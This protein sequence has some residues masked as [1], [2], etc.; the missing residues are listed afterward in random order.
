MGKLQVL[1]VESDHEQQRDVARIVAEA[2]HDALVC[3]DG[4]K[5]LAHFYRSRPDVL[6]V[7]LDSVR[8]AWQ[9]VE[10]IRD[11]SNVPIFVFAERS[12]N[13]SLHRCFEL[14]TD[15][16]LLRP[17]TKDDL[18]RSFEAVA[19]RASNGNQPPPCYERNGLRIDWHSCTVSLR[20]EPVELTGTEFRL[21]KYLVEHKGWVLSHDQI[22][23]EVWGPEYRG[24]KDRVKLYVWYLRRKI[25]SDPC[26]PDLIVTKRGLGYS[27]VG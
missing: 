12:T 21:L 15:G 5:G 24:E 26:K 13:D 23:S 14:R 7:G 19:S 4:G 16:F 22:L 18:V 2:G 6:I 1:V 3:D 27:F 20:G 11:A 25:E 17:F 10:R 8:D 9:L